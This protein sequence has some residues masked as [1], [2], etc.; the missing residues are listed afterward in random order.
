MR[1]EKEIDFTDQI[2]SGDEKKQDGNKCQQEVIDFSVKVIKAL[3]KKVQGHNDDNPDKKI[4]L[5]QAKKV[6]ARGAGDCSE[7][8]SSDHTCGEWAMARVNLFSRAKLGQLPESMDHK[9]N[10]RSYI[11]ISD[12]WL[13]S[14]EDFA[15]AKKIIEENNLDYDFGHIEE[16][17][18]CEREE[19]QPMNFEFI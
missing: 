5:A 4:T 17:F 15:N 6:Y 13:P 18:L 19:K 1:N 2:V 7:S 14:E 3:E 8:A 16:L 10:L 12:C 11:D 9:V